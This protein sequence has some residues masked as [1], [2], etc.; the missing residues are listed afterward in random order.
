MS[1]SFLRG[2]G[3][4][5][6][7][8]VFSRTQHH[9]QLQSCI[10]QYQRQ[11]NTICVNWRIYVFNQFPH[12]LVKLKCSVIPTSHRY[13][14]VLWA[15]PLNEDVDPALHTESGGMK[16]LVLLGPRRPDSHLLQ[17]KTEPP[18][19]FYNSP[20]PVEGGHWGSGSSKTGFGLFLRFTLFL[21]TKCIS[22]I[23]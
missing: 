16:H 1:V 14:H 8:H 23:P 19:C 2:C 3:V 21:L 6:I 10:Q 22:S 18:A 13:I 20:S 7:T 12:S 4:R 17:R 9:L 11:T 15:S 5:T